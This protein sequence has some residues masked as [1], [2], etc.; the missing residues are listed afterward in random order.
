MALL[1]QL[2]KEGV[3]AEIGVDEGEFSRSILDV[4]RPRTLHL[5]DLWPRPLIREDR[6][7]KVMQRFE[8]ELESGQVVLHR[9]DSLATLEQMPDAGLDWVYID[10]AHTYE[11]TLAELILC[12]RKVKP[13]GIIAGHDYAV[14]SWDYGVRFGVVNAVNEFCNSY[15][16]NLR[17]LTN[18]ADRHISFALQ[19]A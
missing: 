5:I 4:C 9:G 6:Y 11:H 15:G 16:W 17:W 7:P 1:N 8:Q 14:G 10:S 19:K 3:C 2:P 13:T 12:D 18:E